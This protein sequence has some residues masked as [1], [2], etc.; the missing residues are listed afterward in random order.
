MEIVKEEVKKGNTELGGSEVQEIIYDPNKRYK[1]EPT[2]KF[3][4]E[5]RT[6]GLV[7]NMIQMLM[8]SR[9]TDAILMAD[10][11]QHELKL[12]LKQAVESGIVK[13]APEE[14]QPKRK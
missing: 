2:T 8:N 10:D 9:L 11:A 12:V 3:V 5:G 1:W 6:Y 4:L 7:Y 13:E 14:D